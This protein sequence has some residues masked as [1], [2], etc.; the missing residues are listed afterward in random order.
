MTTKRT[1]SKRRPQDA[2]TYHVYRMEDIT[3]SPRILPVTSAPRKVC[4]V[5]VPGYVSMCPVDLSKEDREFVMPTSLK[6]MLLVLAA[7]ALVFAL[8]V[9]AM[10]DAPFE[11]VQDNPVGAK[12]TVEQVEA[13]YAYG[14]VTLLHQDAAAD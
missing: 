3:S 8:N 2:R 6:V 12:R 13:N 7:V 11:A 9:T 10:A 14:P 4:P 1:V 5:R